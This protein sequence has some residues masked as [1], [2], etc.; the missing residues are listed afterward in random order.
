VDC[1]LLVIAFVKMSTRTVIVFPGMC[2]SLFACAQLRLMVH[3]QTAWKQAEH[4]FVV[5]GAVYEILKNVPLT[6]HVQVFL[7]IIFGCSNPSK[8]GLLIHKNLLGRHSEWSS[9][10]RAAH[11]DVSFHTK[12]SECLVTVELTPHT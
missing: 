6:E 7:V 1:G 9:Q 12:Y 11:S 10:R 4:I 5:C 8:R 3:L 2:A